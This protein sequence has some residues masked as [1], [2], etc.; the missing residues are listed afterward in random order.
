MV[1]KELET[2]IMTKKRFSK[3][4]EEIVLKQSTTYIDAITY[5]VEERGMDYSNI[6]KL[7]SESLLAKLTAEASAKRLIDV[8][9][10]NTLP[11]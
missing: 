5:V 10:G 8:D 7:L 9:S 6:K 3:A 2:K 1:I 11:L 4:V